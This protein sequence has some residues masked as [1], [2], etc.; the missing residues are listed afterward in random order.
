ML[1]SQAASADSCHC[2]RR[3]ARPRTGRSRPRDPGRADVREPHPQSGW[4]AGKERRPV[5]PV[6]AFGPASRGSAKPA[7]MAPGC[8]AGPPCYPAEGMPATRYRT[9]IVIRITTVA[10][11][12]LSGCATSPEMRWTAPEVEGAEE[13]VVCS[14]ACEEEWR[15]AE[16]CVK[17]YSGYPFPAEVTVTPDRIAAARIPLQDCVS[18]PQTRSQFLARCSRPPLASEPLGLGDDDPASMIGKTFVDGGP[19]WTFLVLREAKEGGW[20]QI[21]LVQCCWSWRGPNACGSPGIRR[22]RQDAFRRFVRTGEHLS[23]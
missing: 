7:L 13:E 9:G 4:P 22:S 2:P 20:S 6:G 8:C 14:R 19:H 23:R 15:R 12:A 3:R 5:L 10:V 16:E 21:R 11:A 1:L 17:K 18:V